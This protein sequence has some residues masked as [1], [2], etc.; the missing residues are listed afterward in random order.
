[1]AEAYLKIND[2]EHATFHANLEYQRR[3]DNIDIN[4][5]MAWVSYKNGDNA[6]ALQH[7]EKAM[8]TGS[9]KASL[10]WKAGNIYAKNNQEKRGNDL[11][12]K[13]LK[14]NKHLKTTLL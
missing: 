7:I 12:H 6:K 3:P 5:V 11:I 4:E 13:A 2:L 14:I 1:M 10:L 9:Q 8:R